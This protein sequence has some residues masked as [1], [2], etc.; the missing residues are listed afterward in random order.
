MALAPAVKVVA[1]APA[2]WVTA[3][4]WV[5]APPGGAA[6][7]PVPTVEGP[8]DS[9]GALLVSGTLLA[10]LLLRLT[11]PRNRLAWVSVM[12]LAPA[13]NVAV[14][15]A[16]AWVNTPVWVIAPPVLTS[17]VPVPT[18]ETATTSAPGVVSATALAP[19][20]VSATAPARLFGWV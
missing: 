8:S 18:G 13:L 16:T 5:V 4:G 7:G 17:H 6:R 12:A 2:G 19:L 3:P 9:A 1:P 20:F 11:A 15:A 14:P 10:P